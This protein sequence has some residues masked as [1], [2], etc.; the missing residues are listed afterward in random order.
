MCGRFISFGAAPV[1]A[2][3]GRFM[4]A[5]MAGFGAATVGADAGRLRAASMAASLSADAG[6]FR[7]RMALLCSWLSTG[8]NDF[9][10]DKV[11]AVFLNLYVYAWLL[12]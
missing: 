11:P 8:A 3:T 1:G 4:A 7:I 6:R 2:D 5:S 9:A 12:H 10:L